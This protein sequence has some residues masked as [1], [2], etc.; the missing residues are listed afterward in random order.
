MSY[1]L[2]WGP[3]IEGSLTWQLQLLVFNLVSQN[4]HAVHQ[5]LTSPYGNTEEPTWKALQ[6]ALTECKNHTAQFVK[7]H[8]IPPSAT[9]PPA[10]QG[11]PELEE[12]RAG[13]VQTDQD[14][15]ERSVAEADR[16][17]ETGL[18]NDT[19]LQAIKAYYCDLYGETIPKSWDP[20][21]GKLGVAW[22]VDPDG[23][24]LYWQREA[25]KLTGE[26][27]WRLIQAGPECP[28]PAIP[29]ECQLGDRLPEIGAPSPEGMFPEPERCGVDPA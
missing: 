3:P 21:T 15:H 27:L 4:K 11:S 18:Y 29:L 26:L 14:Q 13:R 24:W 20:E 7:A 1:I 9:Q 22:K 19:Q 2:S 23:I 17:R 12:Q 10:I 5:I 25:D 8:P 6:K 16:S 28:D